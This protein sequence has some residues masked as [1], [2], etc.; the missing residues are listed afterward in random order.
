MRRRQHG[1]ALAFFA[2]VLPLVLLPVAA[3]GV[4]AGFLAARQAHLAEATAQAALDAAQQLDTAA[5]RA[6]GA[7]RLDPAAARQV[8]AA[9][10]AL[11][12]PGAVLDGFIVAGAQLTLT[13]HESVPLQLAGFAG[14][15]AAT[16]RASVSARLT[17]GYGSPSG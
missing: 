16:L 10:L 12:E 1:Q 6:G 13:V 11:Q 5:L 8:A 17:A 7:W 2:L 9:D 14:P 3:F 4:E 15:R